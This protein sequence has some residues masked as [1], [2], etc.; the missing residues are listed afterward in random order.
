[1]KS[2]AFSPPHLCRGCRRCGPRGRPGGSPL[3][4]SESCRRVSRRA[5]GMVEHVAEFG[6]RSRHVLCVVPH[7][8]PVR[9]RPSV[10]SVARSANR[11][12]S[13]GESSRRQCRQARDDVEGRGAV[14]SRSD[15]RHP[16]VE[17]VA[18]HRI[19]PERAGRQRPRRRA[20]TH[21]RRR[22]HRVCQHVGA[23]DENRRDLGRVGVAEFPLR[24]VGIHR[25]PVSSAR[26]LPPLRSARRQRRTPT[27]QTSRTTS[28]S[29]EHFSSENSIASRCSTKSWRSGHHQ[30]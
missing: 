7:R 19:G 9:A 11:P 16:E 26:R 22:P 23:A 30:R 3:V 5:C 17:R 10:R 24:A 21:E 2:S 15:A 29:C 20:R 12:Q 8:G 14:L 13:T 27:A 1:M 25:L 28:S 18:R 6:P 4:G